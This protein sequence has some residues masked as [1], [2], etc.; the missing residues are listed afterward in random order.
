MYQAYRQI[1]A[2]AR[3][4]TISPQAALRWAHRAASGKDISVLAS[5][6]GPHVEDRR[7]W[8][9]QAARSDLAQRVLDVLL[10]L[11]EQAGPQDEFSRMFPPNAPLGP[12]VGPEY[13]PQ[14]VVYP[15]EDQGKRTR[16]PVTSWD[17]Y[18]Q[19]SAPEMSDEEADRLLPPR[20]AAEYERRQVARDVLASR[21]AALSDEQLY[22]ELFGEEPG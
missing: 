9:A 15:G 6:S 5:L 7:A 22:R 4:G 16:R 17:G 13:P 19:A 14:P 10:Q 3:Q 18:T 8:M 20:S 12:E 1:M 21:M 2:A 11:V